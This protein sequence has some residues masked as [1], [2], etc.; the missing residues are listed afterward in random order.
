[1]ELS[2]DKI[3]EIINDDW[4]L[5]DDCEGNKNCDVVKELARIAL[6]SLEA[7]PVY[8][9]LVDGSWTDYDKQHLEELL[10]AKPSTLFRVAY[11]SPRIMNPVSVDADD[12]FYSWFGREWHEHYQHNQYTT[13]AKQMLGVMAE[14]AWKAGR[15]AAMLQGVEPV[16][17]AYKLPMQPLV[18]DSHG[19]LRFKEN[20]IVRKLLDYATL[21]G[22]GLNEMALE[23][24]DA[25]D[26]MQ[27]AQLIG[28]SLSGYGSL[29]YVTD[30]SYERAAATAPQ[31][32]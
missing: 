20:P 17:T 5:M 23:H 22:Y 7:E 15:R 2:R 27:L 14:S 29:S 24:F 26:R 9:V 18:I 28:Y 19:T 4:L 3:K 13:A 8:Q 11:P 25:E 16:T 30:E 10:E 6:A 12:N 1:M 32:E 21:H 31:Q